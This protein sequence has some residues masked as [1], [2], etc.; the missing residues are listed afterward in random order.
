MAHQAKHGIQIEIPERALEG[1]PKLCI[2]LGL[3]ASEW[4]ALESDLT[5]LYGAL[6]GK[7]MPHDRE[8]GPPVH[9]VGFQI[10]ETLVSHEP[11]LRLIEK[12]ANLLINDKDLLRELKGTVIPELRQASKK[13]NNLI[14]AHWGLND[15]EYPDALIKIIGPGTFE[16]YE[17]SDFEEVIEYILSTAVTVHKFEKRV[18]KY[19]KDH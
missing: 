6:L 11:R 13:R 17:K 9:P 5:F 7:T 15:E 1:R 12:L 10:F 18:I 19:F 3:V 2:L 16:V 8:A 4:S 14:H